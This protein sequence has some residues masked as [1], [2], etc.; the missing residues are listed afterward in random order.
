LPNT[1]PCRI[2]RENVPDL[3]IQQIIIIVV[4]CT[5]PPTDDDLFFFLVL[6]HR[7][8]E[9]LQLVFSD[10]LAELPRP[11]KRDE[12]ILDVSCPRF[13]D[14]PYS[15]ETICCLRE[16]DLGEDGLP[17]VGWSRLGMDS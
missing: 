14:Q 5:L 2:P 12:T 16:E 10:L 1:N 4:P 6:C 17:G 8:Q 3:Q 7:T 9:L 15:T 13:F 11:G